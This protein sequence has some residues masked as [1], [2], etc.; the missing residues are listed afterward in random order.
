MGGV[1]VSQV[2][3][4]QPQNLPSEILPDVEVVAEGLAFPEGPVALSDGSVLVTEIDRGTLTRVAPSGRTEVVADCGGGPNG[5]A[6]G[7]D[8]AVYICNNGGRFA[9]GNW[10]GGW[11]DRVDLRT[12]SVEVIYRE[13]EPAS[14]RAE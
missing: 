13:C 1:P 10:N 3:G 7:P 9:S 12:G 5:A 6:I 2:G 14:V 8:G 4:W 11:V